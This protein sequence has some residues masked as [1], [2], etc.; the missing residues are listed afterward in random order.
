M[1]I[2][3]RLLVALISATVLLARPGA[4][5][6][7]IRGKYPPGINATNSGTFP[8]EGLTYMNYFQ[9]FSFDQ[10]KGPGGSRVPTEGRLAVL[11]DHNFFKWTSKQKILGAKLLLLAD[12]PIVT[13][14]L[15]SAALGS[16]NSGGGLADSYFQPFT[17]GWNFSRADIMA[18]YAFMPPTGRFE[19]GATDNVGAGFWLNGPVAGQTV[20]LTKDKKTAAAAFELYGFNSKQEDTDIRPGQNFNIDYS[21]TRTFSFRNMET[22]LRIGAVGYGQYQT[23]DRRGPGVDPV[24]AE[25]THYH[26][27]A[28]GPGADIIFPNRK[29]S[30]GVRYF[31]EFSNSSTVQGKSLQ[32]YMAI[33]F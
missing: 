21:V 20:Y 6:A 19:P 2:Q 30:L 16:I 28:L 12:L 3:S 32:I 7:Q 13:S 18:G 22:L 14:S 31:K 23:T 10:L 11:L 5:P 27:N 33:T 29:T 4:S 9:Y 8:D 26:V 25:S 1:R 24:V 15:T 17:L